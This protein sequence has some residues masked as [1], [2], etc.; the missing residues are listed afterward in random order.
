MRMRRSIDATLL[1]RSVWRPAVGEGGGEGQGA[2]LPPAAFRCARGAMG[3]LVCGLRP[4]LPGSHS[5]CTQPWAPG[6]GSER[7][8]RKTGWKPSLARGVETLVS[9]PFGVCEKSRFQ[10]LIGWRTR[11]VPLRPGRVEFAA[12]KGDGV[13]KGGSSGATVEEAGAGNGGGLP[14]AFVAIG[15]PLTYC[16]RPA[17]TGAAASWFRP[18]H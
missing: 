7:L 15:Q 4:M 10:F 13:R 16:G 14:G 1:L 3:R 2:P 5:A 11:S 17:R 18:G 8:T 12:G 9:D 6:T